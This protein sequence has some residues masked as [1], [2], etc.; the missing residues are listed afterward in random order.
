MFGVVRLSA[1]IL[2]PY[3]GN[4]QNQ[5]NT[6]NLF[7]CPIESWPHAVA[8]IPNLLSNC[9][10]FH[11]LFNLKCRLT[12]SFSSF[13]TFRNL[14]VVYPCVTF[15]QLPTW[16]LPGTIIILLLATEQHHWS[17]WELSAVLKDNWSFIIFFFRERTEGISYSFSTLQSQNHFSKLYATTYPPPFVPSPNVAGALGQ[18][19]GSDQLWEGHAQEWMETRSCA[20]PSADHHI[21]NLAAQLKLF[22]LH[23]FGGTWESWCSLQREGNA[24]RP[25]RGAGLQYRDCCFCFG[26]RHVEEVERLQTIDET[27]FSQR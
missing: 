11:F 12:S 8:K 19:G 9:L 20:R 3:P 27:S 21:R 5:D 23:V 7:P 10:H 22:I 4:D 1:R 15:T 24:R 2:T 16:E 13:Y 17:G 18:D 26:G 6:D 25:S 14:F